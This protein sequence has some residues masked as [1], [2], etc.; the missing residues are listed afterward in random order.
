MTVPDRKVGV[1][2]NGSTIDSYNPVIT[3]AQE[4][5]PFGI[6]MPGRGGHIGTGRNVAGSTVVVGG[7]TIPAVLTVT[8][9]AANLPASYVS[10]EM[11]N[12]EDG[13]NSGMG[14]VLRRCLL[15][16]RVEIRER[17]VG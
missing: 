12:F 4:Y 6:L 8:E 7:D 1:S 11:I 15:S 14:I 2:A 9:R 10:K 5:Y 13:F 3:S 16:R 17:R